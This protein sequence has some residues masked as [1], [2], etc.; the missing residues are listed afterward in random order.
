MSTATRHTLWLTLAFAANF[1]FTSALQGQPAAVPPMSAPVTAGTAQFPPL[2]AMKPPVTV[3]RELLAMS[4]SERERSLAERSP[5][6]RGRILAKLQEY[7][8]M[9]PE[10]RET[11]LRMTE[12]RWYLLSF[13]LLPP[14][15]RADQLALVPEADRKLVSDSLRQW[16]LL[17]ADQQQEIL[18][19][20]KTMDDFVSQRVNATN[21]VSVQIAPPPLPP[22]PF[23]SVSNFIK[24]PPAQRARMYVSFQH[25]F[26]LSEEEK[27]RTLEAL[28]AQQ[29]LQMANA[30]AIFSRL[31]K[32]GREQYLDS[33]DKL[34][35]LSET[36]RQN[37]LQNAERWQALSPAEKQAWR[38]LVN[39]VPPLPPMPPG[40]AFP[41]P[42]PR[43]PLQ[44]GIK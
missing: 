41:P 39:R 6:I 2:P 36:E 28:P 24:L 31:P 29:R 17:S 40:V 42:F 43:Q 12:L 10:D 30:L 32:A 11:R 15:S 44:A 13:I 19:Y 21:R 33:L 1:W 8:T 18:K 27:Q 22:D 37:F 4:P 5:Q 3:F 34:S 20:E 38:T 7:E 16:D 9:K 23:Q 26:D 25:F 14:S 35:S